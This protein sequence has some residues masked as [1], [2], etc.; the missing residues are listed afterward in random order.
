MHKM[1]C[2]SDK[3]VARQAPFAR[4]AA[5]G[6]FTSEQRVA[7]TRSACKTIIYENNND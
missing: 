7:I 4:S 1:H 3:W 6:Y 5:I 2:L